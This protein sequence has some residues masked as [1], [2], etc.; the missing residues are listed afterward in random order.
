MNLSM[1]TTT[2]IAETSISVSASVLHGPYVWSV[3]VRIGNH[4]RRYRIY[5]LMPVA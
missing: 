5:R 3:K 4:L 2:H 1:I